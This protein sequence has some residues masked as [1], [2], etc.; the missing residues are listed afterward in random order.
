MRFL[1]QAIQ[2]VR[3]NKRAYLSINAIMYGLML[4]GFGLALIF[5]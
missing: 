2:I 3:A 5:P 1:C 4:V